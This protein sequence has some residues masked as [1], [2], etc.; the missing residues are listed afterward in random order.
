MKNPRET[1]NA[2]HDHFT[3][4]SRIYPIISDNTELHPPLDLCDALLVA[5]AKLIQLRLKH[6]TTSEFVETARAI[7][8]RCVARGTLLIINDRADIA[9]L[10]AADG[11]HLGQ[12]DLP[13]AE[14]R[15][16][17]GSDA[18]IGFSTH[19]LKQ[20]EDAVHQGA[21]DY[22]ALGPIFATQSKDNPDP[23]LGLNALATLRKRCN[24]PL[25]AI[26]GVD[27][28]NVASVFAAGA[29]CAAIIGALA[30]ATNPSEAM[31]RLLASTA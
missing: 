3:F 18:L 17:L 10:V 29:D 19:N 8:R 25:V 5:G 23:A 14:A 11:L 4:P 9:K 12:D 31:R 28:S 2:A 16:I 15:R 20:L 13:V 24:L 22:L 7:K 30:N 1:G 26:G 27:E 6:A 21:A